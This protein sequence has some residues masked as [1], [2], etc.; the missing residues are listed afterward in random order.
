M[1]YL[2][3]VAASTSLDLGRQRRQKRRYLT[4]SLTV[5]APLAVLSLG[6]WR[7]VEK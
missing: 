6:G 5:A 3:F 7:H 4:R 1:A 2:A